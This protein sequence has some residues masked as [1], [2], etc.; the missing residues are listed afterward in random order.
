MMVIVCM[1]TDDPAAA[2]PAQSR[3]ARREWY[4]E[5]DFSMYA[6]AVINLQE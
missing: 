1:D 3:R 2:G 6:A 4:L 5:G